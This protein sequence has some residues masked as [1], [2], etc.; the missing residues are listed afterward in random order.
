M[1]TMNFRS[2]I[3]LGATILV[4]VLGSVFIL[5]QTGGTLQRVS[6]G[7]FILAMGMLLDNAVVI[8]DGILVGR[9]KNLSRHE[10][11]TAIGR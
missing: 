9:Q 8:V 5:D 6:L 2:G 4:T 10:A 1:I 3:I 7:S 11:L